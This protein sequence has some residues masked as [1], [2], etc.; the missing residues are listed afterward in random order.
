MVIA[1]AKSLFVFLYLSLFLF[2]FLFW[3][4]VWCGGAD[5]VLAASTPSSLHFSVGVWVENLYCV[6]T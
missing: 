2:C 6:G 4:N 5:V 1:C 3:W